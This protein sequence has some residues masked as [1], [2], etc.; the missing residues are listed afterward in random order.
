MPI[1]EM[2]EWSLDWQH[3][4]AHKATLSLLVP[5]WNPSWIEAG[6]LCASGPKSCKKYQHSD[7]TGRCWFYM[8]LFRER[9]AIRIHSWI[10]FWSIFSQLEIAHRTACDV[11]GLLKHPCT[12]LYNLCTGLMGLCMPCQLLCCN[13]NAHLA[14]IWIHLPHAYELHT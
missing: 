14:W 8:I 4:T 13:V 2:W 7:C 5:A 12:C 3:G 10:S 9:S 6:R 1:T 11:F